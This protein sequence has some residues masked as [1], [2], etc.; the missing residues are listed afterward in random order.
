M[1]RLAAVGSPAEVL[2]QELVSRVYEW[3]IG[4]VIHETGVP[5]ILHRALDPSR[6]GAD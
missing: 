3:P 6:A 1:G 4:I 5:Q 2:T